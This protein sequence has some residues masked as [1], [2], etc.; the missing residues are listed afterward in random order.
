MEGTRRLG[1]K[2]Q[3]YCLISCM[4][5]GKS[6]PVLSLGFRLSRM[7]EVAAICLEACLWGGSSWHTLGARSV[8]PL[9]PLHHLPSDF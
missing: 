6:F 9:H 8:L 4:T 1:F 7:E 2:I 5:L 3:P